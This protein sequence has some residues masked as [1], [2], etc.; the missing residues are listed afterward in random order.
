MKSLWEETAWENQVFP[1]DEGN[2]VKNILRPPWNEKLVQEMVLYPGLQL[3]S[4][5]NRNN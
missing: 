1:L 2:N 3:L 4:D 5:G